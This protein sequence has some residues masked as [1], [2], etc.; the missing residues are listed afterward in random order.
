MVQLDSFFL[1]LFFFKACGLFSR[2]TK[3]TDELP[4][5]VSQQQTNKTFLKKKNLPSF[6]QRST[7]TT[8]VLTSDAQ[9]LCDTNNSNNKILQTMRLC[10]ITKCCV[11]SRKALL[12]GQR[13]RGWWALTKS[14]HLLD[15]GRGRE[16]ISVS[17]SGVPQPPLRYRHR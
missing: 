4:R 12:P 5:Q 16:E 1:S 17:S 14:G 9:K 7:V 8:T 10:N 2:E 11:S 3:Q 6:G 13:G 15:R